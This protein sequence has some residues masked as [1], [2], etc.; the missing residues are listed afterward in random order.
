MPA[1]VLTDAERERFLRFPAQIQRA[2]LNTFFTLSASDRKLLPRT[3]TAPN[4]IGFALQVCALRYLGF[5]PED[6]GTIPAAALQYVAEQVDAEPGG[7]ADYGERRHTRIDH[8]LQAQAH[9]RLRRP[10]RGDLD[11]L[12]TWLVARALEHD[13]PVVL[14]DLACQRLRAQGLVRPAIDTL[15]RLVAAARRRAR[16]ETHRLVAPLL[17]EPRKKTLDFLL[18]PGDDGRTPLA[19]LRESAIRRSPASIG[20]T[21]AKIRELQAWQVGDIDLACLTP[22]RRKFLAQLGRR[23]TN[24]ALQRMGP[25]RRYPILLAFLEDVHH[26]LVDEAIDLFDR[27][28]A[29][30]SSKAGRELDEFRLNGAR[31]ANEKVR[32]LRDLGRIVLD[33]SIPD[34][35]VRERIF[36]HISATALREA[37][38]ECDQLIRPED[39]NYFDLLAQRYGYLRQF[40]PEFLNVLAFR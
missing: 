24:Q 7:L 10:N 4:R 3:A 36:Q 2:D 23:S 11:S 18:V 19:R 14:V 22:N 27:C 29:N 17:G 1:P 15:E 20:E 26:E 38:D 12:S 34:A 9:L 37:V 16:V 30:T 25:E 31:A 21:V 5:C 39:D 28:L 32:L 33:T 8:A 6:L 13:Q 35:E 40:V